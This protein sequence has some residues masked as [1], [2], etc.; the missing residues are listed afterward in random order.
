MRRTAVVRTRLAGHMARVG[1]ARAGAHGIQILTMGQM[2]ARLAGDFLAPIDPDNLRDAVREALPE[3][4]LGELENIKTLPGMLRASVST[5]DKVWRA[6]IDLS[7]SSHPRLRALAA[8]EQK[9]LRRL[10]PSMKKPEELVDLA[11]ARIAHA[12]AVPGPIEIHGHSEMPVSGRYG[13]L[14]GTVAGAWARRCCTGTRTPKLKPGS[15]PRA[16]RLR[17]NRVASGAMSRLG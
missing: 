8:L 14:V 5:F 3:T 10:P 12:P 11:C 9:V 6:A 13:E 4:D 16:A 2:A 15:M 17:R 1:A 7:S